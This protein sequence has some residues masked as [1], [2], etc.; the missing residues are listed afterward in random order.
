MTEIRTDTRTQTARVTGTGAVDIRAVRSRGDMT[1]F[2]KLPWR[3]YQGIDNWVPPLIAERR[4]HLSPKHNPFFEHAQAEYFLALRDG[5]PVGRI[6]AHVDHRFNEFQNVN[7]GMFG[8][9]ECE[10]DPAAAAALLDAA[11]AWLRPLGVDRIA[12]PFDFSTN[13]EV[14][15]L[16]EGHGLRPQILENWHHPYYRDLLEGQGMAKAMDLY[17][18]EIMTSDH[19]RMLPVINELAER[20]E[21]DHG[22]RVRNMRKRDFAAELKRFMEVYNAAWERNW[23]FVPLTDRE[24]EHMAKELKPII[25]E[26]FALVAE[27]GDEVIGVSLSLPDFNHVLAKVNGRLLPLGWLT[28][29]REQRRIDEA[30]VFALGVKRHYHHTGVAAAFYA[31]IW[32]TC[33]RKGIRRVE[34]G[35]ILET[36]EP[37]NRAMEALVGRI[38]KRYRVYERMLAP[39]EQR[40]EGAPAA[41]A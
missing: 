32:N 21:P 20:L 4:K 17:K 36:N 14:G 13:H 15:V 41:G 8:F 37:M 9:F 6:G 3:L 39:A 34:T 29:L 18:W 30:R 1:A 16:V 33:E 28:A 2:I 12:G 24:I 31:N 5:V 11:E 38:V 26:D 23:G 7:W 40:F 19:G 22:I 25:D 10:N 27:K 35:W